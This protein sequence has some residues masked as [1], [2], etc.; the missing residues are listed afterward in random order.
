MALLLVQ[1]NPGPEQ[2]TRH[3]GRQP[4]GEDDGVAQFPRPQE[5]GS[6]ALRLGLDRLRTQPGRVTS[7]EEP[8]FHGEAG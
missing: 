4:G 6:C 1:L 3:V 7:L 5:H 8:S 2:Q